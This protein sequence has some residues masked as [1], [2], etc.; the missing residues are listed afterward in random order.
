M[1]TGKLFLGIL[2]GVTA[3]LLLGMSFA[4]YPGTV[5]PQKLPKKE[6]DL[7]NDSK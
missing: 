3:G 5:A 2:A 4:P 7:A 1:S 6:K